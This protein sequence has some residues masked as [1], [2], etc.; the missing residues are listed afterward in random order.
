[1]IERKSAVEEYTQ[2]RKERRKIKATKDSWK[3]LPMKNN[4]KELD[5]NIVFSS[6]E[7]ELIKLGHIPFEMEDHWFMYFDEKDNTIN[8]YRSWSGLPVFRGYLD[9]DKNNIFKLEISL[10]KEVYSGRDTDYYFINLFKR[11]LKSE[12]DCHK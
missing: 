5:I 4:I 1:M 6:E 8:Y 11:L 7:I 12:I 9:P 3:I 10:E 2:L